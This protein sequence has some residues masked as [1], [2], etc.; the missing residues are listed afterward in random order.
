MEKEKLK[1]IFNKMT[2][3]SEFGSNDDFD[4]FED[5]TNEI[6]SEREQFVIDVLLFM[7]GIL[8]MDDDSFLKAY[9][10]VKN[11]AEKLSRD[12]YLKLW[13]REDWE[14]EAQM[15]LFQLLRN[16]PDLAEDEESLRRFFKTKFKNYVMDNLRKQEAQKRLFN[17]MVYE[18][19]FEL[20]HQIPDNNLDIV[21]Y[22]AL[23][24]K[25]R[26]L[27]DK[28]SEEDFK[29]ILYLMSGIT[30]KGKRAFIKDIKYE[31]GDFDDSDDK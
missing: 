30:F 28:L 26:E 16:Q 6:K 18:D 31:F 9:N 27:K 24:D 10:S 13:G 15:V 12:F 7:K 19:I 23:K 4:P 5:L 1:R 25:L 29:K 8:S 17:K 22:I 14:Q 20:A 11:I 3:Y 2:P 21:D